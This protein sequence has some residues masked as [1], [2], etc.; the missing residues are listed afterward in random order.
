[1]ATNLPTLIRDQQQ[2]IAST[3]T[4]PVQPF[5]YLLRMIPMLSDLLRWDERS[6]TSPVQDAPNHFPKAHKSFSIHAVYVPL[7]PCHFSMAL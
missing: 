3:A 7:Q 1:M 5:C 2:L 4:I 6:I